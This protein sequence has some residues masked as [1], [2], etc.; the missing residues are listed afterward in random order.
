MMIDELLLLLLRSALRTTLPP[1]CLLLSSVTLSPLTVL[2]YTLRRT[3]PA[4]TY[5]IHV[6]SAMGDILRAFIADT[7]R[8]VRRAAPGLHTMYQAW[9]KM[10]VPHPA[11]RAGLANL[12]ISQ[13]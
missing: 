10:L 11:R 5:T 3:L 1:C 7:Y 8:S 9:R 2:A 13:P 6:T 4:L 12:S